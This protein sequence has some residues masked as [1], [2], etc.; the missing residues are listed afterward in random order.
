MEP[1][2]NK[3]RKSNLLRYAA[4]GTELL[5]ILGLAVWGGLWLDGKTGLTPLF[6]I[7]LPLAGLVTIFVQL[8]RN[9]T[10]K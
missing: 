5:V 1:A 4:L 6:L 3:Q 9:L 10:K 7:V 2:E 8:Y